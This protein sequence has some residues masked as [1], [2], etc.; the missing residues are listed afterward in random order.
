MDKVRFD[1]IR[2]DYIRQT[3]KQTDRQPD[4]QAGQ[5]IDEI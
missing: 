1:L 4:R 3:D 2:L 5:C